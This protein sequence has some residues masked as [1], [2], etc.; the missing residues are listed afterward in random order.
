MTD[1]SKV[2]GYSQGSGR[3][4]WTRQLHAH[5]SKARVC[6]PSPPASPPAIHIPL[7]DDSIQFTSASFSPS[8]KTVCLLGGRS[9]RKCSPA[10]SFS[11]FC[12]WPPA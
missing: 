1:S 8:T 5:P 11:A 10:W 7:M 6:T 9:M 12:G 4:R 2:R 3:G